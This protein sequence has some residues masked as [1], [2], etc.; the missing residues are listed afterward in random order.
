VR[1]GTRRLPLERVAARGPTVQDLQE[2]RVDH[3]GVRST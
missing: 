2:A 1:L 3:L